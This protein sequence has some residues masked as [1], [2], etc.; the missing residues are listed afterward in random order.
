MTVQSEGQQGLF[1]IKL[2]EEGGSREER[3]FELRV[4]NT[5]GTLREM[6]E[7]LEA[8]EEMEEQGGKL[9]FQQKM[10]IQESLIDAR[11]RKLSE[12]DLQE[13]EEEEEGP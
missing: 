6:H 10:K 1:R 2:P 5:E 4:G 3:H 9:T 8:H 13:E 12:H 11:K 7:F